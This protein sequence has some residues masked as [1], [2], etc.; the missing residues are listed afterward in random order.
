MLSTCMAALTL[1]RAFTVSASSSSATAVGHLNLRPVLAP[2]S[3]MFSSPLTAV[4]TT[5]HS[6][7][8]LSS[9]HSSSFALSYTSVTLQQATPTPM[10][11]KVR[12]ISA[13]TLTAK[14]SA[15]SDDKQKQKATRGSKKRA[16][17]S[18]DSAADIEEGNAEDDEMESVLDTYDPAELELPG[19]PVAHGEDRVLLSSLVRSKW[20]DYSPSDFELLSEGTN[21]P[22]LPVEFEDLSCRVLLVRKSFLQC[23]KFLQ[24]VANTHAAGEKKSALINGSRGVGK[25]VTLAQSVIWARQN[26]WLCLWIPSA[27]KL[28]TSGY[29]ISESRIMPGLY[30]QND[31]AVGLLKAFLE[32]NKEKLAELPLKKSDI[33][34]EVPEE[35]FY[36]DHTMKEEVVAEREAEIKGVPKTFSGEGK[37]LED[38]VRFGII[39]EPVAT[40]VFVRLYEELARVVEYPVLIAMD[41]FNCLFG[42]SVFGNPEKALDT[43]LDK[44][45][46]L[47]PAQRLTLAKVLGTILSHDLANGGT[48]VATTTT[49]K[50]SLP[51]PLN[52]LKQKADLFDVV[53]DPASPEEVSMLFG[54]FEQRE[55]VTQPIPQSMKDYMWQASGGCFLDLRNF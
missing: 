17:E 29:S 42:K 44:V 10:R 30:D 23:I 9:Y 12:S 51:Q 3:S 21:V 4:V 33:F 31:Y 36:I 16:K 53:C 41:N 8:P 50:G 32:A 22:S 39:A 43:H 46:P 2:A 24:S 49:I 45:P 52:T 15:P 20:I 40:E 1:R 48:L 19:G 6:S 37:T 27:A 14:K 25:S 54:F 26:G 18:A 35:F 38:L 55:F 11:P 34:I 7:Q 13:S 47:L 5:S 28:V